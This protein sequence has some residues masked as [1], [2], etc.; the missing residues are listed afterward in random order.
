M[1][2]KILAGLCFA[3]AL[4]AAPAA[5]ACSCDCR[6]TYQPENATERRQQV[7]KTIRS[8]DYLF[9]GE[10][11]AIS[12]PEPQPEGAPSYEPQF[13][14]ITIRPAKILK[15]PQAELI[16]VRARISTGSNC[17]DEV[18]VGDHFR[19]L[20]NRSGDVWHANNSHCTC[21]I[22]AIFADDGPLAD[23]KYRKRHA[24]PACPG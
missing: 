16:T 15:G 1:S 24:M 10:I 12:E 3:A 17:T 5:E 8:Y 4:L 6:G 18:S 13:H 20:A 21:D 2:Q 7:R 19:G 11:V 14:R 23:A 22:W 9:I